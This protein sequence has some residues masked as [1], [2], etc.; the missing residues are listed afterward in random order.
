M[1]DQVDLNIG[2]HYDST[3]GK[4]T[5]P[6]DGVYFASMT[7]YTLLNVD[8]LLMVEPRIQG[9]L[10]VSTYIWHVSDI[11]TNSGLFYCHKG[12]TVLVRC[13][14]KNSTVYGAKD[15]DYTSL[16]IINMQQT[17]MCYLLYSNCLQT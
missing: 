17:G 7:M 14:G 12:D 2:R 11:M 6:K 8:V 15:R 3:T 16:T 5:C 9:V 10:Y 1:F 13:I 4:F